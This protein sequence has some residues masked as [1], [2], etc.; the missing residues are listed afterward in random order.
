MGLL[1][2]VFSFQ[3]WNKFSRSG[4]LRELCV[5]LYVMDISEMLPER[6]LV[7]K[8]LGTNWTAEIFLLRMHCHVSL[9][10]TYTHKAFSTNFA[11]IPKLSQ[12]H[13][14]VRLEC[15]FSVERCSTDRALP[16]LAAGNA[17]FPRIRIWQ[18]FNFTPSPFTSVW[19]N[20]SIKCLF[21]WWSFLAKVRSSK[22]TWSRVS[23][24]Q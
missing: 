1:R 22:S 21:N 8:Q 11:V 23:K 9:Q 13:L 2:R 20:R 15:S 4:Y 12:V 24:L 17:Y 16:R 6:L 18:Q 3:I 10:I 7:C 5:I 14:L 19:S